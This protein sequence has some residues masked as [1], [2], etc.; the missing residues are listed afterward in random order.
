MSKTFQ[1]SNRSKKKHVG[2]HFHF[3]LILP[4]VNFLILAEWG[5]KA[6]STYNIF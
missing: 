3:D 1:V 4:A 5:D 6:N 2:C